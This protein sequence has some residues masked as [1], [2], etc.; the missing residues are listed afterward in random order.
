MNEKQAQPISKITKGLIPALYCLAA[1]VMPGVFLIDL[2]NRN[3][4][5][6][7]IVF[8]H[9]A[10]ILLILAVFSLALFAL[11]RFVCRSAEAALV[12][13]ILF[14]ASFW[15]FESIL[16][17]AFRIMPIW[18]TRIQ[19]G[20]IFIG[21]VVL[22]EVLRWYRP[23]FHKVAAAFNLLCAV[24]VVLFA[25]SFFPAAQSDIAMARARE[26]GFDYLSYQKS[27]FY[28]DAELPKPDIYW[29]HLDGMMSIKTVE[30][31]WGGEFDSLRQELSARGFVMYEDARLYARNTRNAFIA[32]LSPGFYDG[33]FGNILAAHAP[34]NLPAVRNGA[35]AGLAS[36]GLTHDDINSGPEM[37][38]AL[39]AGGYAVDLQNDYINF[40]ARLG[41]MGHHPF[42]LS[43]L[44]LLLAL[45]TP[46]SLDAITGLFSLLSPSDTAQAEDDLVVDG[47]PRFTFL[48][49]MYTH[50][51]FATTELY[52]KLFGGEPE[53][54]TS[55]SHAVLYP[56]AHAFIVGR[57]LEE[58]DAILYTNPEAVIVL[59]AD[60]GFHSQVT[61][62]YKMELGLSDEQV[63]ELHHSVFSAV[64]IPPRYGGL[65]TPLD[66][67]NIA[68]V[69]VNRFVGQNY[70]LLP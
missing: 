43:D 20:L 35:Q 58:V 54:F 48:T 2:Y 64:R 1:F 7:H 47:I 66:P 61:L 16:S 55:E 52:P 57:M 26:A 59:Q 8:F 30:R 56:Y 60:H 41:E 18:G 50:T 37:I 68:R 44:P 28:V 31:Y 42:I 40:G 46:F 19:A 51:L 67:R 11:V 38:M 22:A 15:L 17:F 25:V 5:Y 63:I 33:F 32:L 10:A 49:L 3:R 13:L 21:L 12:V 65:G 4:D 53:D 9:V 36:V 34:P 70:D 24:I 62:R 14:W 27:E 23:P 6:N 29:I 39:I 45:S 69:L